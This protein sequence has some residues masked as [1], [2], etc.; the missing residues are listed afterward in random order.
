[1]DTAEFQ[2]SSNQ[3][4]KKISQRIKQT[5]KEKENREEKIGYLQLD[6]GDTKNQKFQR[7]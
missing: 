3:E 1:M 6:P 5:F 7:E 2:T 4:K